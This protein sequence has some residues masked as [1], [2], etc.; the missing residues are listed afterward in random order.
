MISRFSYAVCLTVFFVLLLPATSSAQGT[1]S[2]LPQDP[3]GRPESTVGVPTYG[4]GSVLILTVLNNTGALL[5]R[6]AVV[7]LSNKKDGGVIWR[8]TDGSSIATFEDVPFGTYDIEVSA[9]GYLPGHQE[10]KAD[11]QFY[12]Y[13]L[14]MRVKPD[15]NAIEL[16]TPP[17]AKIP[18]KARK[19]INRAVTDL[20]SG[21][22][23]AAQKKLEA[24][25]KLAPS[26]SEIDFLLG[27][28]FFQKQEYEQARS[29]LDKA[30]ASDPHNAQALTLSGRV[31]VRSHD[32]A[33]AKPILEQAVA[34]N[35]DSWMAHYLLA[36]TYL[37]LNEFEKSRE[38]A[39]IAVERGK[40]GGN[41]AQIVLGEAQASLGRDREAVQTLNA[42]LQGTPDSPSAPAVRELVATLERRES[43]R[44]FTS[45]T[46]SQPQLH[47]AG[48]EPSLAAVS[49]LP[50]TEFSIQAWEPPG[51]DAV[52]P[53]VAAG[54]ACPYQQVLDNVGD[55]VKQFA[56]DVVRFSAIEGLLHE[57]LDELGNPVSKVTRTFDYMASIS[58]SRP[59][60]LSV[61]EFRIERSGREESPDHIATRGLPTLAFV[62]H[63]DLRDSF[64]IA[65]EGLG[66]WNGQATWLLHFRQRD[67]RPNRLHEYNAG[68]FTYPGNLK[69]RAWIAASTFQIVRIESELV[70]PIPQLQIL[71][72]H[73]TVEYGPVLFQKTNTELWLP[74]KA[75]LYLD[76]HKRHYFRRLSFD[77]FM[78]FSVDSE[79]AV[80]EVKQKEGLSTTTPTAAQPQ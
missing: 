30:I 59:G 4:R 70:N 37:R 49:G 80:G 13:H 52:N 15:P 57:Q 22:W 2:P 64:Q 50:P 60:Y 68:G 53:P 65:C 44:A 12:S 33:G 48:V 27:Y 40:G 67:D 28:L 42:F 66:Q 56:D 41:A 6:Q 18:S 8:T 77:H 74:K 11:L 10:L 61:D 79:G 71:N 32:F 29:S 21:K 47:L 17:A 19:Q 58:N 55:R 16:T 39:Q 34:A 31:R 20:K 62:F 5:D 7:K 73:Q 45:T 43:D 25:A 9:V 24:A 38:Q 63:P 36:E 69:G 51:I 26:D 54:V 76:V 75:E 72:E 3:F 14:E 78:L 46:M 1:Q 23:E 35:P